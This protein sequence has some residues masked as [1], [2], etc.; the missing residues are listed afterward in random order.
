MKRQ[1]EETKKD[2]D[3]TTEDTRKL[4]YIQFDV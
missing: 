2:D 3:T 1:Y 4:Q